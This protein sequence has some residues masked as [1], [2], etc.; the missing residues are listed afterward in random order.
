MKKS[1]L[2]LGAAIALFGSCAKEKSCTCYYSDGS[3]AY[4]NTVKSRSN[5]TISAFEES[6]RNDDTYYKLAGGHCTLQ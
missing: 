3:E 5:A 2:I 1:I 4:H 6:C